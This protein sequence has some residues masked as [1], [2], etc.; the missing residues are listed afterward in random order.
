MLHDFTYYNPTKIHFGKEAMSKLPSELNNYGQNILL[1]YG[2]NSIKKFGI[3]D[4]VV[5]ILKACGKAVNSCCRWWFGYR[6][7][8]SN[9]CI[10]I[11]K[12]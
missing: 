10:G 4:E 8:K 5:K 1:L 9:I 12:G 6:L 2:K 7:C 3:Y 11:R